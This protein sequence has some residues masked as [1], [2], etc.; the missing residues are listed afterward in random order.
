MKKILIILAVVIGLI[1]IVGVLFLGKLD[2]YIAKVIKEEGSK[3][4][5]TTVSVASVKTDLKQG[6]ASI[7]GLSIANPAGYQSKHA[8]SIGSFS[9]DVDYKEQVIEKISIL[10]PVIN[11]EMQGEKTNF[12]DLLNNIPKSETKEN[13]ETKSEKEIELLIKLFELR[14]ATVNLISDQFGER[15]FVMQDFVLTDIKGTP[16]QISKTLAQKLTA[17]VS[18]QVQS[19]AVAEIKSEAKAKVKEKINEKLSEKVKGFNLKLK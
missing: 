7:N 6:S 10:K 18:G 15:S 12:K 3:A 2:G 4:L 17:H 16:T 13:N 8:I 1:A 14:Q 11:A 5:G 19:F 9:A